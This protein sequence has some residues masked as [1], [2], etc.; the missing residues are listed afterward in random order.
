MATI[1]RD[2][3]GYLSIYDKGKFVKY[4][5]KEDDYTPE[6]LNYLKREYEGKIKCKH[7]KDKFCDYYEEKIGGN[8]S[9]KKCNKN[10]EGFE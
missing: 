8:I 5:G 7:L 6:K 9:K 1:K 4:L 3:K 10:C 2:K